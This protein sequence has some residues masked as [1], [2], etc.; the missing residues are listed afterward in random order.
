ML[1]S[2]QL[3][4]RA[5]LK[6][7]ANTISS[8]DEGTVESEVASNM[9][10]FIRDALI[11]SHPWTF[12]YAQSE[13][14]KI[15][16]VPVA[17]YD[18]AYQLPND[19]LRII[20]VGSTALGEGKG[21]DYRVA[22]KKLHTNEDNI[23]ISFIYRQ[24]EENLP[25]FFDNVLIATLAAE[26]CLPITENTTRAELLY[27]LAETAFVKAKTIDSQQQTPQRLDVDTLIAVR[28]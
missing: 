26:F 10:D 5:L 27:K 19:L 16:S 4:S 25:A 17:D 12:S 8:F 1:S 6:I 7:G 21:V 24:S 3:S 18:Y 11:S 2:I 20:S 13:L 15:T 14:V 22:E 28:G 9:Y 23:I